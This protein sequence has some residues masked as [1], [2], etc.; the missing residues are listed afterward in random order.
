MLNLQ[1]TKV[2][3]AGLKELAPLKKLAFL[4]LFP[5]QITDATLRTL[6]EM[7]MLHVLYGFHGKD[8]DLR[9][10]HGAR[11]KSLDEVIYVDLS[12]TR[13]TDKGLKELVGMKNLQRLDLDETRVTDAGLKE[14]KGHKNLRTLYLRQGPGG[15]VPNVTDAGVAEL[16][17]ALPKCRIDP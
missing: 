17:K 6:R 13:V 1:A 16:R 3:E 10:Y 7:N 2:T 15:R 9:L 8:D 12:H 14:L 4:F 5:P 11:L